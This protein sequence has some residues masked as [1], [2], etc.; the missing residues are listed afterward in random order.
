MKL[1]ATGSQDWEDSLTIA[2]V[3][4]LIIQEMDKDDKNITFMHLDRLGA[5]QIVSSYVAKTKNFLVGKGFKISEFIPSK[6]IDF[7]QRLDK[8]LDQSPDFM[9]LLFDT[10]YTMIKSIKQIASSVKE[11]EKLLRFLAKYFAMQEQQRLSRLEKSSS[12]NKLSKE[13]NDNA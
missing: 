13:K 7:D 1:W 10:I 11:I 8:V 12:F 9:V 5:E 2:R 4:T 3:I 6:S